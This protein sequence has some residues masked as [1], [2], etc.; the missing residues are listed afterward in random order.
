MLLLLLTLRIKQL[1]IEDIFL[2]SHLHGSDILMTMDIVKFSSI[3][4]LF[5]GVWLV[6]RMGKHAFDH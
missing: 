4:I 1:P 3:I 2:L 6:G 5:I